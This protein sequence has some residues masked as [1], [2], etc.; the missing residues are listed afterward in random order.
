LFS[1][2]EPDGVTLFEQQCYRLR[3]FRSEE[4]PM[5]EVLAMAHAWLEVMPEG[6]FDE[7]SGEIAEDF[8]LRL[9]FVPEGIP[10]EFR[11]RETA[12]AALAGSAR[13]RGP[14]VLRDLVIRATDDPE[15][16]LATARGE[17]TM[18]SGK[19]YRNEYV[20]LIRIREG[21]VIEHTEYLNPLAI[22][23]AAG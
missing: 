20:I 8:V 4:H 1:H 23:A 9:P 10:S 2:G 7:F 21:C 6:R 14:L 16:V 22:M 11:G 3:D 19:P 17:A 12:R 18:A 5:S 15:L 13:N